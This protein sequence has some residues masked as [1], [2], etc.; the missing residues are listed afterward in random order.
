MIKIERAKQL[1]Q[2]T[3]YSK[4]LYRYIMYLKIQIGFWLNHLAT[5]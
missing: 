1:Q 2:P 5:A 3:G 4:H